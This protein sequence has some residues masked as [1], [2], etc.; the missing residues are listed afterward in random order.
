MIKNWQHLCIFGRIASVH[1]DSDGM[2]IEHDCK[3]IIV[4][5]DGINLL[6]IDSD[7][8]EKLLIQGEDGFPEYTSDWADK[9]PSEPYQIA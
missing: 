9:E 1:I 4:K 3:H 6:Y 8:D 7:T 2:R 5:R